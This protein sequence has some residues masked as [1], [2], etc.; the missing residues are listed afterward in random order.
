MRIQHVLQNHEEH[1]TAVSF[2][3]PYHPSTCQA[4]DYFRTVDVEAA[5]FSSLKARITR[6]PNEL[7]SMQLFGL[8]TL[9]LTVLNDVSN[10]WKSSRYRMNESEGRAVSTCHSF[11]AR[12][13]VLYM[14]DRPETQVNL[15]YH[16]LLREYG[17]G[18]IVVVD[19]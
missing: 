12:M 4:P 15:P 5:T 9:K 3:Y 18:M 19:G 2:N 7:A 14:Q 10:C 6:R 11:A 17:Q 13:A 16:S 1:C 8:G